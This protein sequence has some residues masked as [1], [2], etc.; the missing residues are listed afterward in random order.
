PALPSSDTGNES[1]A[2]CL[3]TLISWN[4]LRKRINLA[5]LARSAAGCWGCLL[6]G[7]LIFFLVA[8]VVLWFGFRM[9]PAVTHPPAPCH[10]PSTLPVPGQSSS[11]QPGEPLQVPSRTR[12]P[13]GPWDLGENPADAIHPLRTY[14]NGSLNCTPGSAGEGMREGWRGEGFPLL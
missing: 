11:Q 4:E 5:G 8:V 1:S 6:P 10:P 3:L 9:R 13:S 12:D 7:R 14:G 2:G